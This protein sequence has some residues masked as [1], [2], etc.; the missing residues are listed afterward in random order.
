MSDGYIYTELH[1][2]HKALDELAAE[3]REL[4]RERERLIREL[5][6]A[7]GRTVEQVEAGLRP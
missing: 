2:L 6:R 7:T 4:A 3:R 1:N 5:A